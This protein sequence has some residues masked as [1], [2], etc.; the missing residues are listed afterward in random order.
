M[1]RVRSEAQDPGKRN[2]GPLEKN[3]P[4]STPPPLPNGAASG[5]YLP[6]A[7]RTRAASL[8]T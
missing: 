5:D 1:A 3:P 7:V 4:A 6:Q 2:A 8:G